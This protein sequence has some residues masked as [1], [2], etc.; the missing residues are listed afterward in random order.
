MDGGAERIADA[1]ER[2]AV[3]R[4]ARGIGLR[5]LAAGVLLTAAAAAWP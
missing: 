1:A 4:H 3:R 2:A 5:S